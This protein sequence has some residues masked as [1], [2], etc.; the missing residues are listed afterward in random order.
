MA[1]VMTYAEALNIAIAALGEGEAVERLEALKEQLAKRG[2]GKHGPTKTQRE[3]EGIKD[4]ILD[5]LADGGLTA[6]E[7]AEVM[8]IKVQKASALLKQLV[9]GGKVVRVKDGKILRFELA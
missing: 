4:R 8:E 1:K 3:N 5:A 7:I 6:T 9:D 2:S